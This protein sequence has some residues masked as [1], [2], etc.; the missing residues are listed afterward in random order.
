MSDRTT[1]NSSLR[2]DEWGSGYDGSILTAQQV[3][4]DVKDKAFTG[5]K[6][7]DNEHWACVDYNQDQ[8]LKFHIQKTG[9]EE[10]LDEAWCKD[11]MKAI[12]DDCLWGGQQEDKGWLIE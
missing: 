9:T 11:V 7:P 2:L 10:K 4:T 1:T 6:A 12:V 8:K 3:C 5:D